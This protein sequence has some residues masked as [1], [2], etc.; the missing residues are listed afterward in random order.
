MKGFL[1]PVRKMNF[2]IT[3]KPNIVKMDSG[4]ER[5]PVAVTHTLN[6]IL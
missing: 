5:R 2:H 4:F 1:R 6:I 3:N